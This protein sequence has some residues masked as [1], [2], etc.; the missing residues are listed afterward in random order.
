MLRAGTPKQREW[1]EDL[2]E[3]AV[4]FHGHDGPFMVVGLRMGLMALK[5]L[6]ACGWFDLRCDVKLMWSPP[7]SCVIDGIQSST[8]CTMG[9]HNIVVEEEDG[10]AAHFFNRNKK[11]SVSLK[12]DILKKIRETST[13]GENE[14]RA[15]MTRLMR[16]SENDIFEVSLEYI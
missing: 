1:S 12:H 7:D 14:V 16:A 4:E 11:L 13:E 2:M 15:L 8:G 9:K 6:D 5:R 10:V 3:K